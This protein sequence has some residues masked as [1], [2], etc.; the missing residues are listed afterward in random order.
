MRASC[1][2]VARRERGPV[3]LRDVDL[4]DA[5]S[6]T[7]VAC[8]LWA[9]SESTTPPARVDAQDVRRGDAVDD[10][11]AE[12][13]AHVD[14]AVVVC[15]PRA[16]G[17]RVNITPAARASTMRCTTSAMPTS[18]TPCA[19]RYASARPLAIDA[20]TWRTASASASGPRTPSTLSASPAI[21]TSA[22][23]SHVA[24]ERTARPHGERSPS[25]RQTWR[26]SSSSPRG[27]GALE[28]LL[29][30]LGGAEVP[31]PARGRAQERPRLATGRELLD[32]LRE[33]GGRQDDGV[34]HVEPVAHEPREA[35]RLASD[36]ARIVSVAAMRERLGAGRDA[37]RRSSSAPSPGAWAR[38]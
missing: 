37:R 30:R 9:T 29:A 14:D 10:G 18:R 35:R 16:P 12:A 6:R 22:P 19:A 1:G 24:L 33:G 8:V 26:S 17:A 11:R 36:D 38:W 4:L 31:G 32:R 28:D 25:S 34:G 27:S 15:A 7:T 5:P 13:E 3:G 23:S 21:E 2:D 20:H